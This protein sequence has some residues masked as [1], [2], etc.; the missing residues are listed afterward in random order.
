MATFLASS[1]SAALMLSL[2]PIVVHHIFNTDHSL[3]IDFGSHICGIIFYCLSWVLCAPYGIFASYFDFMLIL[4]IPNGWLLKSLL[5]ELFF[6][7]VFS[8]AF[9]CFD[10][11]V[12]AFNPV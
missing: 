12:F 3:S 4:R 1:A 7:R 5:K 2:N 6:S 8:L 10:S 9:G 11:L